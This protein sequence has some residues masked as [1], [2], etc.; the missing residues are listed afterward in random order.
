[1]DEL[2]NEMYFPA[3]AD[4]QYTE[5]NTNTRSQAPSQPHQPHQSRTVRIS[6]SN[7][8]HVNN[9]YRTISADTNTNTAVTTAP[10]KSRS[11]SKYIPKFA[12]TTVKIKEF[13]STHRIKVIV[14]LI[15]LIFIVVIYG[16]YKTNGILYKKMSNMTLLKK[17]LPKK[18]ALVAPT[19]TAANMNPTIGTIT[20]PALSLASSAATT[21]VPPKPQEPSKSNKEDAEDEKD[22]EDEEEAEEAEEAEDESEKETPLFSQSKTSQS[23]QQSDNKESGSESD[24][25]ISIEQTNTAGDSKNS[26][27][28]KPRATAPAT[29]PMS[30]P[31]R[32]KKR[33][34][35]QTPALLPNKP[36]SKRAVTSNITLPAE[37]TEPA[38]PPKRQF[39]TNKEILKSEVSKKKVQAGEDSDSYYQ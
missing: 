30:A 23:K 13:Y 28:A 14:M 5:A 16:S 19:P 31:L 11:F 6:D 33:A 12:Q 2:L 1:M 29:K 9:Q 32:K 26:S 34:T 17:L 7:P 39:L 24:N 3:D 37:S 4:L 27:G 10:T 18:E 8:T 36:Q 25:D 22:E 38:K 35:T 20:T 15:V 21:Q